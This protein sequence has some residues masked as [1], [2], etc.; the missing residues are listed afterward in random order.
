MFFFILVFF[1]TKHSLK[2]NSNGFSHVPNKND[3][4]LSSP[5]CSNKIRWM[6]YMKLDIRTL[7]TWHYFPVCSELEMF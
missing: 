3:E 6:Q 5:E 4:S 2:R 1:F 7:L